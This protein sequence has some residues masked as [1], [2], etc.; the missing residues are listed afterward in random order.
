MPRV[1]R[2]VVAH[3]VW[4]LVEDMLGVRLVDALS[5]AWQEYEKVAVARGRTLAAP[6]TEE[7]VQ[8]L[9]HRVTSTHTPEVDLVVDGVTCGTVHF[10][11]ALTFDLSAATV[12][13]R[14]GH[15]VEVHPSTCDVAASLS[16]EDV[17][18]LERK[19]HVALPG[20]LTVDPRKESTVRPA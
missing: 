9:T 1:G 20:V 14:G 2:E 15:V 8:L 16:C 11:L 6:G 18:L 13:V 5:A 4:H 3:E 7:V 19:E 10:P 17:L 12:T